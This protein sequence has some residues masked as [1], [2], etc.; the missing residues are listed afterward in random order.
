MTDQSFA[1]RTVVVCSRAQAI[2][3]RFA[4]AG[5]RVIIAHGAITDGTATALQLR[6]EG[7]NTTFEIL[8]ARDAAQ[9]ATLVEQLA[10]RS[11]LDVWVNDHATVRA[12]SAELLSP[13][14]WDDS[15]REA[16]SSTFFCAQAAGRHM[17]A[18]RTGVIINMASVTGLVRETGYAALSVAHA[19]IIALTEAL[20]VEW[21]P[22]GVRVVGVAVPMPGQPIRRTP[23]RKPVSAD[24]IAEAV[25]YLASA[26]ASYITAETLRVDGGFT[27]HQLF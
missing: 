17:L 5:A 13:Q 6:E 25:L 19:G 14:E 11:V 26:Q 24:E 20:G 10:Q 7:L 27:A 18:R 23:L 16:L 21:A 2:A 8:D 4:Q 9:C 15:L 12:V 1:G 3:R 22:R